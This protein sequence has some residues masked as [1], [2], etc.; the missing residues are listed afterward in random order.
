MGPRRRATNA[1]FYIKAKDSIMQDHGDYG[2]DTRA[3]R[4]GDWS[5]TR[6]ARSAVY[7]RGTKIVSCLADEDLS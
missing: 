4:V 2:S 1:S 3:L 7:L 5:G 6:V